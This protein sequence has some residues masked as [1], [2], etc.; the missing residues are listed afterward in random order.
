V[1]AVLSRQPLTA[2]LV[3]TLNPETSLAD[4]AADLAETG[5]AAITQSNS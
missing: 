4:L 1:A 3:T 5:Y 2:A